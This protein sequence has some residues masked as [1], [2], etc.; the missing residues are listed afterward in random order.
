MTR[1]AN[2]LLE[3]E[4]ARRLRC[5]TSKVKRLRLSGELAY[6]P[7]RPVLIAAKDVQ[8]YI[9]RV[10]PD[11]NELSDEGV[12]LLDAIEIG[13]R[14]NR[15]PLRIRAFLE[16][17]GIPFHKKPRIAVKEQDLWDYLIRTGHIRR[18][19]FGEEPLGPAG[20]AAFRKAIDHVLQE[21]IAW[22]DY[23]DELRE[24]RLYA[25]LK[26]AAAR[27]AQR[28]KAREE[29]ERR[30]QRRSERRRLSP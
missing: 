26:G 29:K 10:R 4:V 6:L 28:K 20:E 16:R 11:L 30:T 5:S 8:D 12:R 7:G 23:D 27:A 22:L 3:R 24:R 14:L 13:R 19:A 25:D 17:K 15:R 2:L 9:D 18:Y 1:N 21:R